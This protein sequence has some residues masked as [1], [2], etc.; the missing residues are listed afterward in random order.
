MAVTCWIDKD[1]VESKR[2][3][4]KVIGVDFGIETDFKGEKIHASVQEG[5]RI[6]RL[7]KKL[8]RQVKGSRRHART[9]HLIRVEYQKMTNCKDDL[10]NKIVAGLVENRTVVIQ[11]EMLT[12]Q[13]L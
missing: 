10:A 7:Q 3:N 2:K 1:K 4:N 11:D 8:A 12:L 13:D 6:K 5:E 9:L